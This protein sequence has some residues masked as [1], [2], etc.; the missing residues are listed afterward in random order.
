MSGIKSRRNICRQ[1]V[2]ER[3]KYRA[4]MYIYIKNGPLHV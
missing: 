4:E 2:M 3:Q 1:N